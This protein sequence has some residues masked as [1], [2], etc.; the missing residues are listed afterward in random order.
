[1]KKKE[2]DSRGKILST[3][4]NIITFYAD[5]ERKKGIKSF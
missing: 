2:K 1:M 4:I 5:R 3:G